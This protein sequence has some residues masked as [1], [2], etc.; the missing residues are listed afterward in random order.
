MKVILKAKRIVNLLCTLTLAISITWGC[1]F[2]E[3]LFTR[4]LRY[5]L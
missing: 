4:S 3:V 1:I 5:K 2:I